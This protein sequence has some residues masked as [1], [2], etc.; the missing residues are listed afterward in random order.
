MPSAPPQAQA[1]TRGGGGVLG[2]M[3]WLVR[4]LFAMPRWYQTPTTSA[5]QVR[6]S[7][8]ALGVHALAVH[9]SARA[10]GTPLG[11]VIPARVVTAAR[12]CEIA[13]APTRPHVDPRLTLLTL[14]HVVS[15]SRCS[16]DQG[17]CIRRAELTQGEP[18]VVRACVSPI[19]EF[20]RV[21]RK[22]SAM[23][24]TLITP[25]DIRELLMDDAFRKMMRTRP[26][27]PENLLRPTLTP[28]WCVWAVTT[29][30]KWKRGRFGTYDEA[31]K[32]MKSLLEHDDIEDV[33]VTSIRYMM[34]PPHGFKWQSRKYPWCARCRR[35]SL[36]QYALNH[37][38]IDFP[39]IVTD[40][41]IRCFYCGI[42]Q[43]ALPRYSPR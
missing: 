6:Q 22:I 2:F 34:P 19:R 11:R 13:Q 25:P 29:H 3:R 5:R 26:R 42:R 18:D 30:G 17:Y 21:T 33:S 16:G 35:P 8:L 23:A 9:H 37:R 20:R 1:S 31:Y 4:S 28:P 32:K 36:F 24:L 27:I 12:R 7:S 43:A 38:A 15:L 10:L 41:P 14:R 39:E 40:E